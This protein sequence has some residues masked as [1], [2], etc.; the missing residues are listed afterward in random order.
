VRAGRSLSWLLETERSYVKDLELTLKNFLGPMREA[1]ESLPAALRGKESVIF[2]NL[3]DICDFHKNIFLKEL[4]KYETMPEDVGHCFVTW[5][6]KF[7]IYVHY[8][9]NKPKSTEV[10][11]AAGDTYFQGLQRAAGVEQPISAYLIKPVQRITKYQLLLKDLLSCSTDK[12]VGEIKEGLDVCL[13]VPRKANDA[14]HLSLLDGCDLTND[15]LGDVILQDTFQV[16]DPKK[17]IRQSRERRMFLFE[18]YLVFS[19][20]VKDSNGKAKYL[21]KMKMLTSDIG[22]TE[23]VEGDECK[24]AVWTGHYNGKN[25]PASESKVILKANTVDVKL[26]WIRRMRQLIQDTYFG[27]SSVPASLPSLSVPQ[28][29]SS[30]ISQRSSRDF[31][32]ETGS[33]DESMENIERGS[34]ASFGS[35]GTTDSDSRPQFT[36]GHNV[37]GIA[38][39]PASEKLV[40]KM[41]ACRLPPRA[42]APTASKEKVVKKEEAVV[43]SKE[44]MVEEEEEE[45]EEEKLP[46]AMNAMDPA[47]RL[48]RLVSFLKL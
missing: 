8:C 44:V 15:R 46:P 33:L 9:T 18:L 48:D 40:S 24:F 7:D 45:K 2:A 35:G 16:W 42:P 20:E 22:I 43:G 5:A 38:G 1:G 36:S 17:L 31:D 37:A 6:S 47:K 27:S 30:T 39:Q 25:Q 11:M 26:L 19:K 32:C 14:L 13:S 23:H 34:L 4:E 10:L 21:Y 28:G 3:E 12:E 41:P 29:K